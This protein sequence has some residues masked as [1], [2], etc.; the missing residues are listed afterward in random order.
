MQTI[1]LYNRYIVET[2]K[3]L[4]HVLYLLNQYGVQPTSTGPKNKAV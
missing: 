2:P 4:D 3:I 1:Q